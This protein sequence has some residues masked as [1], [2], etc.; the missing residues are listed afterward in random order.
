MTVIISNYLR[1]ETSSGSTADSSI[2]ENVGLGMQNGGY[3]T[4]GKLH[5]VL[6]GQPQSGR[7]IM[8]HRK[9]KF[10][11]IPVTTHR[12]AIHLACCETVGHGEQR[13]LSQAGMG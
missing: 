8:S 12:L 9:S 13:R 6:S 2:M 5:L 3:G 7:R 11:N 1:P 10:K 4:G